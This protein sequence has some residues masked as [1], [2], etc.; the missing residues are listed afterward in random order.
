M[1][2]DPFPSSAHPE[3]DRNLRKNKNFAG[4]IN[5]RSFHLKNFERILQRV[6]KI[7]LVRAIPFKTVGGGKVSKNFL[8]TPPCP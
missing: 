4:K 8:S 7:L 5:S 2:S 6:L 1:L 3:H